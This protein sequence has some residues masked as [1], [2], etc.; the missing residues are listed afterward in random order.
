MKQLLYAIALLI[1][2]LL[3]AQDIV[4]KGSVLEKTSQKP[5]EFASVAFLD[6]ETNAIIQETTSD[7]KGNFEVKIKPGNYHLHFNFLDF[8]PVI[9]NKI[10]LSENKSLGKIFLEEKT[11][12]VLDEVAVVSEK[13]SIETR[14]DKKIFNVGKDL[15]SKGG[16]AND[17]LN[18]VPSVSVN[19]LGAVSLRGNSS[20]RIL[21]NGKPS[22]MTQN[23]GLEQIPAETIERVEVITNPSAQYDAQGASGIINIILKKNKVNGFG[24]SV[25]ATAGLP[26][27]N[28]LG[29]NMNYKKEKF[30]VFTDIRYGRVSVVGNDK[31]FRTNFEN[32]VVT[33][34]IDQKTD[35]NR[36]FNRF[37]LYLGSDYYIN[38][39]NTLT[40]SYYYRNSTSKNDVQYNFDYLDADKNLTQS[41]RARENYKEPQ[42]SNQI[43]LNYV[44][45]FEKK[46]KKL[47]ANIQY[48]FWNDD[49]NELITETTEMPSPSVKTLKSRDIESSKDVVF[50]SD[51][52]FPLTEKSKFDVGIKGEIR[53]I[54][55]DYVV[56]DNA[57]QIDSLTNLL[58]YDER[59]FGVY[60]Q[61]SNGFKKFQ[62]QLGLRAEHFNTGS[63]D[64]KDEFKT[65]KN[66]TKLFPTVHLTYEFK[67][68]FNLQ[69]SY[70]RRIDRPSFYQLNPFG[71]I[72]DRRNI[73][74]G[75]P[76]L[77]PMYI[78]SYELGTL[79]KWEKFTV[80]PSVY[81][82]HTVNL[83]DI[84]VTRNADDYL[85]EKPVN[86]GTENRYGFEVN[87]TFTPYK[88]W[89]LSSDFNFYKFDQKGLFTVSDHSWTSKLNS[90]IKFKSWT[91]QNNF[92]II[93]ARKSGQ[94]D[95][96]E[97]LWAD[98]AV[99]KEFWK[100]KASLTFK[101]D[102]IFD[103][104]ISKDF[105]SGNNYT[106]DGE[107]RFTGTRAS[108]TFTYKFNRKKTDRDR[109]PE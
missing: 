60:S 65:D 63:S 42:I 44:K 104:R 19:A 43:E 23:N 48:D 64:L 45:T 55:S 4:V 27:N 28:S 25:T 109:L 89:F 51:I 83:F 14:L 85:I 36:N 70:S 81:H 8:H 59:I 74:I 108:V 21:I 106:I 77:N 71:G 53:R 92:N 20:V 61:Y 68:N 57:V 40:L 72:A 91:V 26:N 3:F 35:R 47:T 34:F 73:R 49:E 38:N 99:A 96:Q 88:W 80:N 86:L 39:F 79:Y 66:Y 33:G 76:D 58:H 87:A 46:G 94:I 105:I 98:M 52:S 31:L 29:V 97:Q 2:T 101:V 22:V 93:G 50:Q 67:N 56:L 17:I 5:I 24:S 18:N 107:R 11:V 16:S 75:N 13:S 62:Y 102:N 9:L 100:E 69:L 7:V 41:I 82:Q 6:A 32:D 95:S 84:T 1:P 78:D 54:N 103:S 12:K 90:R 30:N 10:Q 15:I 37:N